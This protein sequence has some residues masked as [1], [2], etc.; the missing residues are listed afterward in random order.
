MCEDKNSKRIELLLMMCHVSFGGVLSQNKEI[1]E[2]K[3]SRKR[4][5]GILN[6][7][8]KQPLNSFL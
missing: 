8:Q 4:L 2:F 3:L 5:Q 6:N 1:E 7:E